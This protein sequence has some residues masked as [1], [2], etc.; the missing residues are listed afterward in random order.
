MLPVKG[1]DLLLLG[2]RDHQRVV[3]WVEVEPNDINDFSAN[4]ASR[5]SLKVFE[6]MRPEIGGPP[7]PPHLPSV[8]CSTMRCLDG[9]SSTL[10]YNIPANLLSSAAASPSVRPYS[11]YRM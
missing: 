4:W 7:A 2:D 1:L 10:S 3:G 9:H 11:R 8:G 5:L 6:P